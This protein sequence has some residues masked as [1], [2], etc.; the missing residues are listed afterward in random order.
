[1]TDW[2]IWL[3][4][5]L[6]PDFLEE[7]LA[8]RSRVDLLE[9]KSRIDSERITALMALPTEKRLPFAEVRN[10]VFRVPEQEFS[11]AALKLIAEEVAVNP[12]AASMPRLFMAALVDKYLIAYIPL[13]GMWVTLDEIPPVKEDLQ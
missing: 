1:M 8:L 13:L 10:G 7:L 3:L 2:R 5:L 4:E 11:K 9:R 12:L 6:T